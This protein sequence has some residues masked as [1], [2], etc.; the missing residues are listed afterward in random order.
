MRHIIHK[1]MLVVGLCASALGF[2]IPLNATISSNQ[3][4]TPIVSSV[5]TEPEKL[6]FSDVMDSGMNAEMHAKH[7]SH[8][9]HISHYS[10]VQR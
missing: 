3:Q 5:D 8:K 7:H 2:A 6:Y 10:A 4:E 9:S 1:A